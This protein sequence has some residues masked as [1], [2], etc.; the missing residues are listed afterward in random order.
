MDNERMYFGQLYSPACPPLQVKQLWG[1]INTENLSDYAL[2]SNG[3]AIQRSAVGASSQVYTGS[4]IRELR[5]AY[6]LSLS[7]TTQCVPVMTLNPISCSPGGTVSFVSKTNVSLTVPDREEP[8]IQ[9]FRDDVRH[10]FFMLKHL[11][12]TSDGSESSVGLA[13]IYFAA[14]GRFASDLAHTMNDRDAIK[15]A[16]DH[17][18]IYAVICDINPRDKFGYRQVTLDLKALETGKGL[19]FAYSL[20]GGEPCQPTVETINK[21]HFIAAAIANNAMIEEAWRLDGYFTSIWI[22]AATYG[23]GSP[24]FSGSKNPLEDVLG[25]GAAMGAASLPKVGN[26]IVASSIKADDSVSGSYAFAE[27]TRLGPESTAAAALLL[28]PGLCLVILGCLFIMSPRS[29][30]KPGGDRQQ[31]ERPEQYAGESLKELLGKVV[32]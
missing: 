12:T 30:W 1:G 19:D 24:V 27:V 29:S 9:S 13:K 7:N 10:N 5:T 21:N 28:P 2:A 25:L 32:L 26:G 3:V 15:D 17:E 4:S 6:G 22:K 11:E 23:E 8:I 31:T 18:E 20:S 16:G 14:N